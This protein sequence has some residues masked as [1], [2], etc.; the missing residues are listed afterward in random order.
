MP[1]VVDFFHVDSFE[2]YEYRPIRTLLGG[3]ARM[4][5][6][7]G[8][9][10]FDYDTARQLYDGEGLTTQTEPSTD[11]DVVVTT[12]YH[13]TILKPA[14][15]G[16]VSIRQIYGLLVEKGFTHTTKASLPFDVVLVPGPY[17]HALLRHM[18]RP[19]MV[20]LPRY[21]DFFAGNYDAA[22]LRSGLG[23]DASRPTVLYLPTWAD[24]SSL[25]D[26]EVTEFVCRL[27]ERY[28]V[29]MKPHAV[30]L[31][32]ER[33]RYQILKDSGVRVIEK[34]A[35]LGELFAVADYCICDALSGAYWE[36]IFVAHK[37]TLGIYRKPAYRLINME[38][39]IDNYGVINRDPRRLE[40]DLED[41]IAY[42]KQHDARLRAETNKYL[43]ATDGSAASRAAAAILECVEDFRSGRRR[44]VHHIKWGLFADVGPEGHLA[45]AAARNVR[46]VVLGRL[47][48]A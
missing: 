25:Q 19:V 47:H 37:P 22:G 24:E 35:P 28:N 43:I 18:T 42:R 23:L 6:D 34:L 16:A 9:P 11:A 1:Q 14:Y 13:Q 44:A 40:H 46:R 30:S 4:V 48:G 2:Y 45:R 7:R 41:A 27:A 36:S 21:D 12:Q 17:S 32:M 8:N 38:R 29:L 10:W 33:E 15:A 26:P 39:C 31:R 3:T 20:G 5:L